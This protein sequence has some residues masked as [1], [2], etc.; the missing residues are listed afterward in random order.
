MTQR[1][2]GKTDARQGGQAGQ[3]DHA[4]QAGAAKTRRRP[5]VRARVPIPLALANGQTAPA[6]FVSFTG[7]ADGREHFAI[8]FDRPASAE[9][10]RPP[11]V[12][13]HSECVTGDV[14]GSTRCDCGRQLGEA[15]GR[16]AEAGGT[17]LY[18][19]QEGR[20]IGLY[21]KLDAYLLQSGGMDTFAANRALGHGEDERTYGVAAEMLQALDIVR[22]ALLSNNPEK[23]RQLEQSGIEVVAQIPTGAFLTPDNRSYLEAKAARGHHLPELCALK[24]EAG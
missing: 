14:F 18:L 12:R 6:R 5:S 19:R 7:L 13:L 20:G 24:G 17:L 22:I 16:L 15:I 11:T 3:A 4:D 2:V 1:A 9:P 8:Q 10:G 21:E 23:R